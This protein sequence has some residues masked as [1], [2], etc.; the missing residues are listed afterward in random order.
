MGIMTSSILL[1]VQTAAWLSLAILT[2]GFVLTPCNAQ[3]LLVPGA[4]LGLRHNLN[5]EVES[6]NY[7]VF[8]SAPANAPVRRMDGGDLKAPLHRGYEWWIV[9]DSPESNPASYKLPPGIVLGLKHSV[10]QARAGITV[11][12]YDPVSGPNFLSGYSFKKERGGDL[13]ASSGQGYYWYESTGE[14]FSDWNLADRLPRWTV[15]GLKHSRNQKD[16]KVT[17]KGNIYD[18]ANP[19]VFPP[20]GFERRSGGDRNG[21]SG[22]GYYWYEKVTGPEIVVKPNLRVKLTRSLF[23]EQTDAPN[24]DKDQDGL[25]DNLE[26]KLA[27]TFRPYLI[28]DNAEKARVKPYEPIILFQVRKM[29][30]GGMTSGGTRIT[31]IGIKWVFLF[32]DDGGYGPDSDCDDAHGGDNDDAFYELESRDNGVTWILINAGLSSRGVNNTGYPNFAGSEWPKNSRF[33]IYDLTHPIIYMSAHKHHEYFTRDNDHDDS[34]YS[35]WGCNDDV[36]GLGDRFLVDLQSIAKKDPQFS[37][38]NNVG[39]LHSHPTL[40]FVNDLG[41]YYPGHSVWGNESFYAV[42]SIKDKWLK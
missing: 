38:C 33:E 35:S 10:N 7:I 40:P 14:A 17:W 9:Q 26:N 39:E 11:F 24:N 23:M 18:P 16:K 28:F 21:G 34:R 41:V 22:E 4:V 5:Q 6:G 20:Q 32:K 36:N 29:A 13:G 37:G 2:L 27:N 19:N 31:R 42:G 30:I 15:L 8:F 1:R 12:G 3:P 25:I